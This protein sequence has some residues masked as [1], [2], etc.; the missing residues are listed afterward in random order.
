MPADLNF[1]DVILPVPVQNF[2]TY[3]LKPDQVQFIKPGCRVIVQF[4]K[5]KI[6]T[7]LVKA[8]HNN[9][10]ADYEVKEVI[11]VLDEKPVVNEIQLKFWDWIADYY[12]CAIGDG[13]PARA[14]RSR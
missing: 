14:G 2:F 8:I 9:P 6:Y 7:A 3:E 10:P 12:M 13:Y 4:G 11:S 5:R 1:I